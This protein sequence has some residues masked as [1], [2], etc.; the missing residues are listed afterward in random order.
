M[1]Q[2][3]L[4]YR[5]KGLLEKIWNTPV[6]SWSSWM[7][8]NIWQTKRDPFPREDGDGL[9][10][11]DL[12]YPIIRSGERRVIAELR[13]ATVVREEIK[14]SKEAHK[15]LNDIFGLAGEFSDQP[16]PSSEGWLL[17]F[18]F[19]VMKKLDIVCHEA[20]NDFGKLNRDGYIRF[21]LLKTKFPETEKWLNKS[22]QNTSN[23]SYRKATKIVYETKS[24]STNKRVHLG[25]SI[26]R[27]VLE[28]WREKGAKCEN[29]Y[30][31]SRA[32]DFHIDHKKPVS[33]GGTNSKENLWV[34]CQ[35][36]NLSKG[37]KSFDQ[38]EKEQL[39]NFNTTYR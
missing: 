25:A 8:F 32:D 35:T 19:D 18:N 16:N 24:T 2:Q 29:P 7:F 1:Q 4:F 22:F 30:C 23:R 14:S 36:C 15:I 3:F 10:K 39:E 26:R 17:A 31:K 37:A 38:W 13:V 34:L 20:L 27:K 33:K 6:A 11:G 9:K 5:S 21:E 12:L 28:D